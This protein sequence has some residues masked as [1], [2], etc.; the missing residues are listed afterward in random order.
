MFKYCINTRLAEAVRHGSKECLCIMEATVQHMFCYVP[1]LQFKHT[2][3]PDSDKAETSC[4][5]IISLAC[6]IFLAQPTV[7]SLTQARQMGS[8]DALNTKIRDPEPCT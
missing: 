3:A 7:I 6:P 8:A 1:I 4:I 5:M 2:V